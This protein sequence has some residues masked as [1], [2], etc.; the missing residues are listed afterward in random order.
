MPFSSE[1]MQD[2]AN[3][4]NWGGGVCAFFLLHYGQKKPTMMDPKVR[5]LS[6]TGASEHK[7]MSCCL[8]PDTA[9]KQHL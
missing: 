2:I 3:S 5:T 8:M 9:L 7:V 4:S 6:H 1:I